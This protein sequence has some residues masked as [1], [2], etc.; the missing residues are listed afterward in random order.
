MKGTALI[1]AGGGGKGAY[2]IGVWKAM[3]ECG[4]DK[5]IAAVSGTSVGGLNGAL[6]AQGD[7]DA[8]ERIWLTMS[9][10]KIL[11]PGK[12]S[13]AE[14]LRELGE[15][16]LL[17]E[18]ADVL[19]EGMFTRQGLIQIIR[20][21]LDVERIRERKIPC[22]AACYN[23]TE[24]LV[25]YI[26]MTGMTQNDMETVLLATSAL[27]GIFEPV[28][29]GRCLYLDGGLKDNIPVKPL[30]NAGYRDFLVVHLNSRGWVDEAEF[31]GASIAQIIPAE[32]QGDFMTG[33][34][35]FSREGAVRRLSQGYEDGKRFFAGLPEENRAF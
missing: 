16:G 27:P 20:Q 35:D 19:K 15:K 2:E 5:R 30:Y 7:Y 12:K 10:E 3:R 13:L 9:A 11:T 33:T 29:F 14:G 28:K 8:A 34:L 22:Y 4:A 1:L 31:P 17:T 23:T 26:N 18:T 32:D 25:D 21:E 24:N 6:F